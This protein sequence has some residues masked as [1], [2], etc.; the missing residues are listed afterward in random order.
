MKLTQDQIN[1]VCEFQSNLSK[2]DEWLF[3]QLAAVRAIQE[4]D[5]VT[6]EDKYSIMQRWAVEIERRIV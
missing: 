4:N 1:K 2:K 6:F 3:F 5:Q